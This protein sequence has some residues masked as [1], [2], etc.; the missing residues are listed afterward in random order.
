M[1]LGGVLLPELFLQSTVGMPELLLE[2]PT[3]VLVQGADVLSYNL[4]FP[5]HFIRT[6]LVDHSAAHDKSTFDPMPP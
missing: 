5:L 6:V 2:L 3:V 1:L 4:F